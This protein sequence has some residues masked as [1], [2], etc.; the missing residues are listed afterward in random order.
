MKKLLAALLALIM[1]MGCAVCA[2][3]DSSTYVVSKVTGNGTTLTGTYDKSSRVLSYSG[4]CKTGYEP[5][6]P[7]E[8]AMLLSS[9]NRTNQALA[10]LTGS[11]WL[12]SSS[13][14]DSAASGKIRRMQFSLKDETGGTYKNETNYTVKNGRVASSDTT[15]QWAEK[16][17]SGNLFNAFTYDAK[18]NLTSY[19]VDGSISM[20][21]LVSYINGTP[22]SINGSDTA[23][24]QSESYTLKTANGRITSAEC[25]SGYT[26][27]TMSFSYDSN[28]RITAV[29]S[30]DARGNKAAV[31]SNVK[32]NSNGT[33]ASM[34]LYGKTYQFSYLKI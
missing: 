22:G 17:N 29:R 12:T 19:E 8:L 11:E 6:F 23:T 1:T 13:L 16:R 25:K 31:V 30:T 21:Y 27:Y 18:G 34:N 26:S 24:N 28:G 2:F 4:T 3:A 20:T 15:F 33:V 9:K 7:V 5:N 10:F 14:S 32:Y